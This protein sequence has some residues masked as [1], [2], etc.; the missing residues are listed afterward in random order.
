MEQ[1]E[2]VG[3]RTAA[4]KL[5]GG[6]A[7]IRAA[8]AG[9]TAPSGRGSEARKNRRRE[10]A[11][12]DLQ[13]FAE[14]YF[15]HYLAAPPSKMHLAL[16]ETYQRAI[17]GNAALLEC[18]ASPR[19][20]QGREALHSINGS[21]PSASPPPPCKGGRG[22]SPSASAPASGTLAG[23]RIAEAAPRGNAKSTLTTLILPLWCVVGRRRRFIGIL[24]DTTEQAAEFLEFIKAELETNERLNLDFPSACGEGPVWKTGHAVTAN[25]VKIKSW[26]KRKRIR[27]ARHGA[28]RPDLVICDDLEDD[29]HIGSPEQREKDRSWFFRALMK[30]GARNTVYIVVGT[31][32]HYDSLL[33]RLL[34]QPGWTG[35]KWRAVIKYSA[36]PLWQE[37]ENLYAGHGPARMEEENQ[38]P[39]NPPLLKGDGKDPPCKGGQGGILQ[40]GENL[41]PPGRGKDGMGV[42]TSS[43]ISPADAF[44]EAHKTEMLAGTEVL[45]PEVE[46]YHYLMKMRVGEGPA[47]FDSE[48]QNEP[49]NPNDCLFQ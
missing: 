39:L 36:S 11:L 38:I 30:I 8:I 9:A 15:P 19:C 35:R 13:F 10:R 24:S 49:I 43:H 37:W 29:E 44:F 12:T 20:R 42:E 7:E 27:G 26:G 40:G 4:K 18:N 32:L 46:D 1:L 23:A 3:R 34:K 14:T 6:Y 31:L 25:G 33:A 41:L 47:F 28:A 16:Y 21:G 5:A 22:D 48:K 45:W 17:A 2:N